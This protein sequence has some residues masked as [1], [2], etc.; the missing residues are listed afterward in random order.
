VVTPT[1]FWRSGRRLYWHG[2]AAARSLRTPASGLPI[3]LTAT[4]VDGLVLGRSGFVHSVNYRSV[5]AFG[6]GRPIEDLQARR[7][8][9]DAFLER[10]YPGRTAELRPI[11]EAELKQISVVEMIIEEATAKVRAGGVKDLPA[12]AG[13]TAWSGVVPVSTRL[14]P[15]APDQ[16]LGPQGALPASLAGAEGRRLDEALLAWARS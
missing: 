4:H 15:P 7:A 10:L 8:A 5:M 12:D 6:H 11:S 14:G 3:C 1:A 13:W 2:A 9:L 16:A